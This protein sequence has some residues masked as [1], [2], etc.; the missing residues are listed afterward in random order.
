MTEGLSTLLLLLLLL[1][2]SL[3]LGGLEPLPP[4][5]LTVGNWDTAVAVVGS[6]GGTVVPTAG[7][8]N[9]VCVPVSGVSGPRWWAIGAGGGGVASRAP[10]PVPKQ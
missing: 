8:I 3:N 4:L 6:G 10:F 1:L 2:L 7:A 5:Q 9:G